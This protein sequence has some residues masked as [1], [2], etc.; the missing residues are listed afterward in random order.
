MKVFAE[1]RSD[2]P[3]GAEVWRPGPL[4]EKIDLVVTLGG[5]GTILHAAS[6]FSLG[7]VPPVLSFSMG[8]LGFL[9]P[10]R[11]SPVGPPEHEC[12]T[13]FRKIDID[14]FAKGLEAVFHGKATLLNRMRLSC[15]FYDKDDKKMDGDGAF[16]KYFSACNKPSP[17]PSLRMAGHERDC[18]APW[19]Q[20]PPKHD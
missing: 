2:K 18:T 4:S 19:F 6:L 9:L 3:E 8:T 10:F 15:T 7:A 12:L 20:P 1:D 17:H 14:D 11:E 16:R 5:D 13:S